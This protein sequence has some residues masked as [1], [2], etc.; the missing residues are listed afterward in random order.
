M[1]VLS[2]SSEYIS[3]KM[4]MNYYLILAE[5]EFIEGNEQ[6]SWEWLLKYAKYRYSIDQMVFD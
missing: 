5:D 4:M 1:K 2:T 6:T 3:I